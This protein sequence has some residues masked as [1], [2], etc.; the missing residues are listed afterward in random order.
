MISK[1]PSE[2]NTLNIKTWL[3]WVTKQ[4][5]IS[6]KPVLSR[7][8]STG[9]ELIELSRADF[10]VCAGTKTGGNILAKHIACR[11]QSAT[12]R[13]MDLLFCDKDPG[14]C[15]AFGAKLPLRFR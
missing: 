6:P 5:S 2:W 4:F 1:D 8:P 10:W 14:K 13:I 12:G 7:F 11:I 15:D 3:E 9:R